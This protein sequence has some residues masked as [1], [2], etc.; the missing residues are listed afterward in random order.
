MFQD[1][2]IDAEEA[3]IA[4]GGE[5]REMLTPQLRDVALIALSYTNTNPNLSEPDYFL[6]LGSLKPLFTKRSAKN[7]HYNVP[8][9]SVSHEARLQAH[10]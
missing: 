10:W 7:H 1:D 4:A 6:D 3:A 2:E 5:P 8:F 9:V